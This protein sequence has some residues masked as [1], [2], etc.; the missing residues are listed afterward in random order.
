MAKIQ[1]SKQKV[2]W[3]L[4][5]LSAVTLFAFAAV[6]IGVVLYKLDRPLLY[7]DIRSLLSHW[8]WMLFYAFLIFLVISHAYMELWRVLTDR[9][10]SP[11]YKRILRIVLLSLGGFL[12]VLSEWNLILLGR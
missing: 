2:F 11:R 5:Q 3:L 8:G 7:E 9:N 6:H 1:H 4:R 10:P 12:L